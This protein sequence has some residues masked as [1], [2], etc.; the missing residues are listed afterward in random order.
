MAQS[1]V[2]AVRGTNGT[3]AGLSP[4]PAIRSVRCPRSNP[5][6]STL[7]P[8]ASLT[9]SP[10]NPNSWQDT[11]ERVGR[12]LDDVSWRWPHERVL[13]IG[14]TAT[15][16]GLDHHLLGTDLAELLDGAFEWQPGWEYAL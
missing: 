8:H 11:T 4:L 13:V 9:R 12:F 16:W 6:S 15:R 3:V 14:H 1:T 10:F 7:T 2:R 5:R